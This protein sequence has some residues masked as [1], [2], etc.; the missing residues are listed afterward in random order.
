MEAERYRASPPIRSKYRSSRVGFRSDVLLCNGPKKAS[1]YSI[2]ELGA[3]ASR[4]APVSPQAIPSL[5]MSN[6]FWQGHAQLAMNS[7]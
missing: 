3:A 4:A 7:Q 6:R 1:T 2:L 5:H